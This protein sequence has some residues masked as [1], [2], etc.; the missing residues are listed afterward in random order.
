MVTLAKIQS[1]LFPKLYDALLADDDPLSNEQDWRNIF[2]YQLEQEEDYCGYALLDGSNV[3]GMI[4]M[5]F[6]RREID[7]AQRKFC[8]LHTWWTREDHRGR[9][10][11]LLRPVL[12]M[13]DYTFTY[14]TPC[15]RGRAVCKRL[16]FQD[17]ST[18]L[19]ILLP[20]RKPAAVENA[21]VNSLQKVTP[22]LARTLSPREYRIW[23]DHQPYHCGHLMIGNGDDS[24]YLLYTHVVRHRLAY[25]HIH[26]VSNHALFIARERDIRAWL[27]RNHRSHFVAVDTRLTKN[28]RLGHS[29]NF[30]SPAQGLY[31]SSQLQPEQI[32]NLY[33]DVVF[34][35]LTVLPDISHEIGALAKR[36][37]PTRSR[38]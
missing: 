12:K 21:P 13:D 20:Q 31:K 37:W 30:W 35:R 14:F 19:R 27:L 4:G 23:K 29:F 1:S 22:A 17:L 11:A 10:L 7:G 38:G 15:D 16:G 2:D 33:S 8:N 3:V 34:L 28:L 25:C 24:C 32:D 6:T 9:S 26:Y 18:Q 36:F 5:I